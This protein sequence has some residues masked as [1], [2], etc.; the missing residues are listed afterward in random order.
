MVGSNVLAQRLLKLW[1]PLFLYAVFLLFPF[2]WM[3]IVSI[4]PD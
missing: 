3:F 1:L 4:R 2:A